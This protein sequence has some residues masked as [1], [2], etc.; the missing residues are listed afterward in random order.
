MTIKGNTVGTIQPRPN[1]NQTDPSK[2]DYLDG[3]VELDEKIN[4][5]QKAGNDAAVAAGK[6]LQK[7]GG[8]MTGDLNMDNHRITGLPEPTND[9]DIVT[10][11]YMETY[12]EGYIRDTLLGGEW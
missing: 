6:A 5:A 10:K 4:A 11:K 7:A 3:K 2:P 12:A 9:S 1:Y 8:T